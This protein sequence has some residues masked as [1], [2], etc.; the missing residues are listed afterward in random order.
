[1][2]VNRQ[3]S[4]EHMKGEEGN[5]CAQKVVVGLIKFILNWVNVYLKHCNLSTVVGIDQCSSYR[6]TWYLL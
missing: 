2:P 5:I 3:L 1:M 6:C 4:D